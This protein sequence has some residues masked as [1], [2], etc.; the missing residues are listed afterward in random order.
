M[1]LQ[2][3]LNQGVTFQVTAT[4]FTLT[5]L[6]TSNLCSTKTVEIYSHACV[7]LRKKYGEF[8]TAPKSLPD[9]GSVHNFYV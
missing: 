2:Q 1:V 4:Y 5:S 7:K 3:T 6:R 8:L 9:I